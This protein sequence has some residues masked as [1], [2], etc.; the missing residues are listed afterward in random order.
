MRRV[1][2]QPTMHCIVRCKQPLQPITRNEKNG[3]RRCWVFHACRH[4]CGD[5]CNY[6]CGH[7]CQH[8][9]RHVCTHRRCDF[10]IRNPKQI[11]KMLVMELFFT[12]S[13][14]A[15]ICGNCSSCRLLLRQSGP[16]FWCMMHV[17]VLYPCR[18]LH[19]AWPERLRV[20]RRR[21]GTRVY[22]P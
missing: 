21:R 19:S 11:S 3:R 2:W 16:C 4:A 14:F 1:V 5:A 6:A 13:I 12:T 15:H 22:C 8:A 20:C 10:E 9:C 17:L 7:A 18:A